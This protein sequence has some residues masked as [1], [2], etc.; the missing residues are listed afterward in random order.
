MRDIRDDIAR[1]FAEG[2]S[3]ALA[4]VVAAWG[5]APRVPGSLMA[6][7]SKGQVA[8]SVSGGCLEGAV[9]QAAHECLET[10]TAV[11]EKFHA[12]TR[13]AREVGLSCGGSVEV[14]LSRLDK[15]VFEDECRLLEAGSEY[16]RVTACGGS[17]TI[18]QGS[19]FL[20]TPAPQDAGPVPATAQ[21]HMPRGDGAQRLVERC[22]AFPATQR[23]GLFEEGGTGYFFSRQTPRPKLVCIGGVHIAIHLTRF[24]KAL[25]YHTAVI[26]PRR[27]FPTKERFPSVDELV[28]A[29]PQ[30]ALAEVG[31]DS[32]SALCALTHDP[33]ID[34]PA[35]QIALDSPAFYIGSLG[36]GKTQL[37][38]YS[39]LLK[40]G[41]DEGALSRIFGPIGLDIASKEPSEI[42]LSIIA[43]IT[44][45]KNG[46][47]TPTS[48]MPQAAQKARN[49]PKA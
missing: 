15:A 3:V 1:W 5:S 30:E 13:Q 19:C 47:A 10:G 20:V 45:V 46:S 6:I 25:G 21:G 48:T 28:H 34:V 27:V 38:R 41:Y 35:L 40:A 2:S 24:A 44:A 14:L 17:G 22:R 16:L 31:L 12:T 9:M 49:A 18:P 36:S 26:D 32:A 43:E 8:G 29:W 11:L 7:S 33:K 37:S 4:Q 42:A 39:Q 23:T